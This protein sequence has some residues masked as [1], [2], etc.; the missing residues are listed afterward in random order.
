[1]LA[2]KEF[3]RRHANDPKEPLPFERSDK[4]LVL[5]GSTHLGFDKAHV[6]L[7]STKQMMAHQ[8]QKMQTIRS[9]K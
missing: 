9:I 8:E 6:A 7:S 1:M 2:D 4:V 5:G 3:Q